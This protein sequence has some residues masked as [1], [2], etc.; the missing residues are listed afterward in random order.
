MP[1][2]PPLPQGWES[3]GSPLEPFGLL[4]MGVM[5]PFWFYHGIRATLDHD[6]W[7][8]SFY[9]CAATTCV[10]FIGAIIV[11]IRTRVQPPRLPRMRS[12]PGASTVLLSRFHEANMLAF[13]VVVTLCATIFAAGVFTNRLDVPLTDG[14]RVSFPWTLAFCA[15]MGVYI[16]AKC[17]ANG[18]FGALHL[19]PMT[20]TYT[21]GWDRFSFDW[22]DIA[23]VS[24][25]GPAFKNKWAQRIVI[26][27]QDGRFWNKLHPCRFS[28]G[29]DATFWLLHY[30]ATHPESRDELADGRAA[31]RV[32]DGKLYPWPE[33]RTG[34]H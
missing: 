11:E 4:T 9:Y 3:K 30:Y 21:M 12:A 25:Q 15:V 23:S 31:A 24:A 32:T 20:V 7:R 5:A 29:D 13:H 6:P 2:E 22:N 18:H 27:G 28:I 17:L 1:L 34:L 8:T 26:V 14:Q 33:R 19:T 10:L 16:I